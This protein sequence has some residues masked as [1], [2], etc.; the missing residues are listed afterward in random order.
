MCTATKT[1][2]VDPGEYGKYND[3]YICFWPLDLLD[4]HFSIITTS[5][6]LKIKFSQ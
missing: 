1:F 2:R 4:I 3:I 5:K 6:Y